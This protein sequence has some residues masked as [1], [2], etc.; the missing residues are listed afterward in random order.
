MNEVVKHKKIVT[1]DLDD[2]LIDSRHAV[3]EAYR[4]AGV[5]MPKDAWGKPA[6][7]WLLDKVGPERYEDV[8]RTKSYAYEETLRRYGVSLVGRTCVSALALRDINVVVVTSA[9]LSSTLVALD[10]L[11]LGHDI[12]GIINVGP[13]YRSKAD[14][15]E[16][17]ERASD[18]SVACH[19]DDM[20]VEDMDTPVVKFV[21]NYTILMEMIERHL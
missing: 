16:S 6:R 8:H 19:V 15:I 20:P 9:S 3:H 1:F 2:V 14:A 5:E 4:M 10:F 12:A 18:W 21:N 7:E 17:L 13:I 11:G